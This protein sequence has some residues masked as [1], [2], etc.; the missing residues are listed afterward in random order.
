MIKSNISD[1]ETD[2]IRWSFTGETSLI[3][4]RLIYINSRVTCEERLSTDSWSGQYPRADSVGSTGSF[5]IVC[6]Q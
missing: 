1:T 4:L 5:Q 6:I 3:R 2:E